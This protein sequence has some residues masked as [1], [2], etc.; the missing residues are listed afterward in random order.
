MEDKKNNTITGTNHSHLQ[1][2][3]PN[4]S[5]NSHLV[6]RGVS[7]PKNPDRPVS[8]PA[9]R[10]PVKTRLSLASLHQWV[11]QGLT[12]AEIA[13]KTNYSKGY[14]KNCRH[15]YGIFRKLIDQS[16]SGDK[17]TRFSK[18]QADWGRVPGATARKCLAGVVM[19]IIRPQP[20][21]KV[22]GA[23][24]RRKPLFLAPVARIGRCVQPP[25]TKWQNIGKNLKIL[26]GFLK[27]KT[28]PVNLFPYPK[29]ISKIFAATWF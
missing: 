17:N 15:A 16:C 11:L 6:G 20:N 22:F 3:I 8:K 26:Q 24:H 21:Q 14:I 13:E 9:K 25:I 10:V 23:I 29:L 1:Q 18:E 12:D 19:K 2:I 7:N 4:I 28:K 5:R 27:E